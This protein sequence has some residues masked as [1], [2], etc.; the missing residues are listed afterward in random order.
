M[1]GLALTVTAG[2][3]IS[4]AAEKVISFVHEQIDNMASK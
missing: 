3:L 2:I 4:G 1:L